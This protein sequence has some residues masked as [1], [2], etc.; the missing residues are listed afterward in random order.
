MYGSCRGH[1]KLKWLCNYTLSKQ[2]FLQ[3]RSFAWNLLLILL[4]GV[5]LVTKHVPKKTKVM[6]IIHLFVSIYKFLKGTRD[7]NKK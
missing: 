2:A 4:M 3:L 7:Y 6:C 1:G 5:S